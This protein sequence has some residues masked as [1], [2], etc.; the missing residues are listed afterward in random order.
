VVGAG[1]T[2]TLNGNFTAD[3]IKV[4]GTLN[5]GGRLTLV[6]GGTSTVDGDGIVNLTGPTSELAF[7]RLPHIVQGLGQIVGKHD[8][9]KIM[10]ASGLTLISAIT[11]GGALQIQGDGSFVNNGRVCANSSGVLL[12]S[13]ASVQ[14]SAGNGRWQSTV[15][16]AKLALA[17]S[18]YANMHGGF[19]LIDG[20]IEIN[21][22]LTTSGR[23]EMSG[24]LLNVNADLA[25][26]DDTTSFADVTG[27]QV[28]VAAGATFIH[29]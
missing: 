22:P 7:T 25:M 28:L 4:E 17:A 3:C 5:I 6:G 24:G 2:V 21:S 18:S 26:G 13:A 16:G 20:V 27:G 9:A 23:L 10:V 12:V 1:S 11:I 15:C 29:H 14:S 19:K 8:D